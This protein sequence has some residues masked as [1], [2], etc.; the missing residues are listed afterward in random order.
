MNIIQYLL[1]LV[2]TLYQQYCWLVLFVCKYIP[3][4]QRAFD[5]SHSP[6]YQKFKIDEPPLITDFRQDWTWKDLIPYY[7][8]RYGKTIKPIHRRSECDIPQDCTCP[9][10]GAPQPYL[11]RNNGKEGQLFC[12]VCDTKFHPRAGR[13]ASLKLRCPFCQHA[14]V[15]KKDRKHFVLWKCV[16]PKCPYYRHN[17]KNVS[18]EHLEEPYGKNN[19][20]LHYIYREFNIDFFKM[21][22]NSLPSNA[23]SLNFSKFNPHIMS[24]CLTMHVNLGLSLRKTAQALN[25][26][27][28]IR[29]SHQMVA[30]YARTAAL[31]IKPFTDSYDYEASSQMA[32]D[33]TYVKVRGVRGYVWLIMDAVKRSILGYRVSPERDV[34]SCIL[35]MRAAFRHI[36]E[37]PK[38]FRFVADGYSA[39]PLAAQQF[40]RQFGEKFRFN[41]T[42]VIGLTNDDAV[43]AEWRPYKQRIERLNRT[44]KS[45]YRVSCGYDNFE[46]ANYNVA[47]WVTYYNFLRPHA[48]N[49]WK[50]L[51]PVPELEA[52]DN[53]PAKWQMLIHLGQQTILRMQESRSSQTPGCS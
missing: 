17:L 35:A 14:L 26:L 42:P 53:M 38:D 20:K 10:C 9:Q 34:G 18:K 47:L 50:V 24:L 21:D 22:I 37:L 48:A 11:Y 36:T 15:P 46:G 13:F 45:T 31:V 30:N 33:E 8:K 44:F 1:D 39:Y 28:G 27:Y 41:V 43:S 4:K 2:Q 25:D 49:R 16:N 5:D 23:S 29:I 7:E 6:K 19:Y 32:A 3:L 12:K 51:N 40:L 52:C